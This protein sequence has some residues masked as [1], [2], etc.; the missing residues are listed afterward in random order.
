MFILACT[1][2][3]ASGSCV[4]Q[5]RPVGPR[6]PSPPLVELGLS[7]GCARFQVRFDAGGA[8][9]LETIYNTNHCPASELKLLSDTAGSFNATTGAL[10]IPVVIENVGTVALVPRL[11]LR[12]NADSVI[13]YDSLNNVLGGTSD[14]VGYLP[15]SASANG[16]VAF[17]WY[18]AGL[19]PPGQPQVLMP[20]GRTT[21]RWIELRGT[22]WAPKMRLKLLASGVQAPSV[23]AV[24]PDTVPSKLIASLPTITTS[25]GIQLKS[26]LMVV[27]FHDST[28]QTLRQNAIAL[29]GGIVVGGSRTSGADGWYII[30][31]PGATTAALLNGALTQLLS[32][33]SVR[34]AGQYV[35]TVP[36]DESWLRP[37]D[38]N[39]WK[40][41]D[42]SVDGARGAGANAALERIY[43]PLAWGCAVGSSTTKIALV[44]VGLFEPADLAPNIALPVIEPSPLRDHG[45]QVASV[46]AAHGNNTLGISG[47][48]WQA[49]LHMRNLRTDV[50]NPSQTSALPWFTAIEE[51][52]VAAGKTGASII[53]FAQNKQFGVGVV[54]DTT[55]VNVL[56]D[57]RARDRALLTAIGR[58]RALNLRPLFVLSAGN[59]GIDARYGGYVNAKL[60][61]PE[62]VLVV[63]GLAHQLNAPGQATTM[64]SGSKP[65]NRGP[66]VE[67]YA[68]GEN[69]AVLDSAGNMTLATGTSFAM[70]LVAGVAGLLKSFDPTLPDTALKAL[71]LAGS[72]QAVNTDAGPRPVLHAYGA[73]KKAAERTGAPL[74]GNRVW[75]SAG[76]IKVQRGSAVETIATA[77]SATDTIRSIE[78]EHGGKR[79]DYVTFDS[80]QFGIMPVT[81]SLVWANGSWSAA[82]L[83]S[84]SPHSSGTWLSGHG[85]SHD[86]DTALVSA[87]TTVGNPSDPNHR[88]VID[89]QRIAGGSFTSDPV[90]VVIPATGYFTAPGATD[91]FPTN[92]PFGIAA[93]FPVSGD[94]GLLAISMYHVQYT[95]TTTDLLLKTWPQEARLYRVLLN[96]SPPSVQLVSTVADSAVYFVG[97]S[98]D[99]RE[100]VIA[101]GRDSTA[102]VSGGPT[103]R[104]MIRC[105][106]RW[107]RPRFGATAGQRFDDSTSARWTIQS[108]Q[109]WP[110]QNQLPEGCPIEERVSTTL[111]SDRFGGGTIAPRFAPNGPARRIPGTGALTRRRLPP[112]LS[113]PS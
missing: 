11:K 106:L 109:P 80:T 102:D 88:I 101:V 52:F 39:N 42:W 43:G 72:N 62:Q 32:H 27:H 76:S 104:R 8:P 73:L 48:M 108:T 40:P 44:D 107:S 55:D 95:Q 92:V 83:P 63:G 99:G 74:C 51:N 29:V 13:R 58:L 59:E 97:L 46:V 71:V 2:A 86:R 69:V 23:P 67:V 66:F 111:G 15:D 17:W 16:R 21:R 35:I 81:R 22:T 1:L 65:T 50:A 28:G 57:I 100:K 94:T 82:S 113:L 24:A 93:A 61:Y 41:G 110:A 54:P 75:A 112:W 3:I 5:D 90:E 20:G 7:E 91:T 45:T 64:S 30:R 105:S 84:L 38:G 53:L 4:D 96:T 34:N 68:P 56:N 36:N 79:I 26:E 87:L 77:V 89:R 70:P 14:I 85:T 9:V 10:R 6:L 103:V 98:E 49:S 18:D 60:T 25:A 19:A 31:I 47:V 78:V 37:A 12:F 33:A